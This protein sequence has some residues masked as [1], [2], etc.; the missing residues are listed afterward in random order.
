MKEIY[1]KIIAEA[2]SMSKEDWEEELKKHQD[3]DIAKFLRA[4]RQAQEFEDHWKEDEE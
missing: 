4:A 3:G 1:D 2:M